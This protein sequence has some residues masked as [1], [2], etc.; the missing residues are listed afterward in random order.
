MGAEM[1]ELKGVC[2]NCYLFVRARGR[3]AAKMRMSLSNL[4]I[5]HGRDYETGSGAAERMMG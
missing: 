3:I 2:Q 5:T 1:S 4:E